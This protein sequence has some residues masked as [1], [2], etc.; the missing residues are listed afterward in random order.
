VKDPY[1]KKSW[2]SSFKFG[3]PDGVA[4]DTTVEKQVAK[5]LCRC[6]VVLL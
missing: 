2:K 4:A 6:I 5:V 3:V 1:L